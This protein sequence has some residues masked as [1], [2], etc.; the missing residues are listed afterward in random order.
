MKEI[1]E[2]TGIHPE[3]LTELQEKLAD[4]YFETKIKAKVRKREQLQDGSYRFEEYMRDTSPFD[5]AQ[6]G[7]F[8]LKLHEKNPDTP[9]SPYFINQ[10][11]L[12]DNVYD[13]IGIVLAEMPSAEKPDACTGIPKAGTKIAEA[14][15]K[16][17]GVPIVDI[18]AK[19]I[20]ESGRRIVAK[21]GTEEKKRKIRIIDDLVTGAD[22]KLE[23]IKAA[24]SM[25]YEVI[26]ILVIID[27]EQGGKEQL[28]SKGCKLIAAFTISQLLDLYLRTGRITKVKYDESQAYLASNK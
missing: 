2:K 14:Y 1:E 4:L 9:L 21:A 6:E 13:Q 12:P 20:T 24:E 15:S 7:E 27:R 28:A 22:T 11:E 5:F 17:S 18:F 3:G 16:A 23:A 19:E 10:R 25:G 8:A 26:D